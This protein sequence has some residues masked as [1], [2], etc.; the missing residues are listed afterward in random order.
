M[1]RV[2]LNRS[3]RTHAHPR[4]TPTFALFY[5]TLSA[6]GWPRFF[7]ACRDDVSIPLAAM[8]IAV[9]SLCACG[10]SPY[11]ESCNPAPTFL[12]ATPDSLVVGREGSFTVGASLGCLSGQSRAEIEDPNGLN[13]RNEAS[14]DD[15]THELAIKLTP[16][17]PGWFVGRISQPHS[18]LLASTRVLAAL[19]GA[20]DL[21]GTIPVRCNSIQ[22]I[23]AT[24]LVCDRTVYFGPVIAMQFGPSD[25]A[26][27]SSSRVW[28][29]HPSGLVDEYTSDPAKATLSLTATGNV[30]NWMNIAA[31]ADATRPDT[32]LISGAGRTY[33]LTSTGESISGTEIPFGTAASM[34]LQIDDAGNGWAAI[35][36]NGQVRICKLARTSETEDAA[37]CTDFPGTLL[38]KSSSGFWLRIPSESD[39]AIRHIDIK[40]G[41]VVASR[42]T[43]H[44][45]SRVLP[46]FGIGELS[47]AAE[48][49][50]LPSFRLNSVEFVD[51][52]T[53][54]FNYQGVSGNAA[55]SLR[56]TGPDEQGHVDFETHVYVLR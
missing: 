38:G 12:Q 50:V 11:P 29:V 49:F 1:R 14:Y 47:V 24:H 15:S 10:N 46:W 5:S 4:S 19:D 32:L 6:M 36:S 54:G 3:P 8:F 22:I 2:S 21:W 52:T 13:V 39:F 26:F 27:A 56:T 17:S 40:A 25:Q 43:P 31:E 30:P 33:A 28:V 53:P 42:D 41:T 9:A 45:R 7:A 18:D 34:A 35:Q 20:Q 44:P 51:Y 16:M 23:D 37:D 48:S 55:W